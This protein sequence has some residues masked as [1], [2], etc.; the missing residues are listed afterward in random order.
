[1]SSE[2]IEFAE[3]VTAGRKGAGVAPRL[4]LQKVAVLGGQADARL[5][6]GLCLAEGAEVTLFSAYGSEL[7]ALRSGSG[8]SLRG[9]GPVGV[10]QVDRKDSPS[11]R[12]TAEL[13]VAVNDADL[14]FLTGPIHKQRTY[15]MVLADHLKDG[16]VLVLCPGRSLGALETAW[17]LR[18]GGCRADIT[19]VEIQ[20]LPYW[21]AQE[22]SVLHLSERGKLQTATLP[23][24]RPAVVEALNRFFPHLQPVDNVLASGFSDGSALVEFPALLLGGPAMG[25]GALKI[26]MGG[27][28][29]EEN[30]NFANLIGFEQ[31]AL[32]EKLAA[33]RI[34]VAERFGV[35]IMPDVDSWIASYAGASKGSGCRTV[36]A[37]EE[38]KA[39]L[40]DGV[41]GSLVPLISAAELAGVD[42]P[43]TRAMVT[44]ASSLLGADIASAGRRL[45]MIGIR[46]NE[47]D[48]ARLRMDAIATGN[49]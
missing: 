25:S 29:L 48:S 36:P 5:F 35:R 32:I 37:L 2:F 6:A 17:M 23:R 12:L 3:A 30:T 13:D 39:I 16:Q 47:L 38:A 8:I 44:I 45:D 21:I 49:A 9:A 19:I 10:Y 31:R 27:T 1:M 40:R 41:I 28:P 18:I 42:V 4:N 26:P 11:V 24:N 34:A 33:E 46:D 22:G 14:I 20:G 7:S 15:A 43:L